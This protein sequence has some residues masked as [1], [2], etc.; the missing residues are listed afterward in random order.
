[1]GCDV[2]GR[3]DSGPATPPSGRFGFLEPTICA[4]LLVQ[5]GVVKKGLGPAVNRGPSAKANTHSDRL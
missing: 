4:R 1:M 5:R 2:P 3:A